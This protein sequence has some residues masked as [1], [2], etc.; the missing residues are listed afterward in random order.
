MKSETEKFIIEN[1]KESKD[2]LIKFYGTEVP[3]FYEKYKRAQGCNPS[4]NLFKSL[5]I[6]PL[7]GFEEV[8]YTSD[9]TQYFDAARPSM[10][11]MSDDLFS[12]LAPCEAV[13]LISPL[14]Y[15]GIDGCGGDFFA[16]FSSVDESIYHTWEEYDGFSLIKDTLSSMIERASDPVKELYQLMLVEYKNEIDN[17]TYCKAEDQFDLVNLEM[18]LGMSDL[19][20]LVY[21]GYKKNDIHLT[22]S[23]DYFEYYLNDPKSEYF[24]FDNAVSILN[25]K[26]AMA[27]YSFYFARKKKKLKKLLNVTTNVKGQ[28]LKF[29]RN[30]FEKII[31]IKWEK[32]EGIY[33][34][35]EDFKLRN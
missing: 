18:G 13:T 11:E 15:I 7:H 4:I 1:F 6:F 34:T 23:Q 21:S 25:S 9:R 29:L 10:L 5:F 22:Y 27:Y 19:A 30:Y 26:L 14:N 28:N 33:I 24:N 31:D 12:G 3:L 8:K 35:K 17:F 2:F 20:L 16:N 32:F